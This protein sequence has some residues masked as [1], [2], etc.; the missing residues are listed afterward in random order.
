MKINLEINFQ[1]KVPLNI[2]ALF[3]RAASLTA[4]RLKLKQDLSVS[5]ALVGAHAMKKLNFRYR[6][7]NTI[8]DVLSFEE[9]NELVLCLPQA[10]KQARSEKH[11]LEQELVFL[12]THGLLHLLGYEDETQKGY[13]VM[14][15][16][17]QE[18]TQKVVK[19]V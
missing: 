7:K 17:G 11:S 3:L 8:T 10:L 12:L 15:K 4:S 5:V 1:V 18:I 6:H 2:R 19:I 16:L 9:V 14:L 13:K